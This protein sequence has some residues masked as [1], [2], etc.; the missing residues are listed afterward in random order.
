M[1]NS[2]KH[3]DDIVYNLVSIQYHALKGGQVYEQY[4]K[5]A[6]EHD[7]VRQFIDQIQREDID[8]AAR[9][10]ELVRSL[11]GSAAGG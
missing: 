11:T 2:H 3:A 1:G 8:R 9:A 6:A 10:L 7:D 5:D 4:K